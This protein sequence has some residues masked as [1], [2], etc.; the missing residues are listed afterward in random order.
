MVFISV[1]IDCTSRYFQYLHKQYT[2]EYE[3]FTSCV[4]YS[5]LGA[6]TVTISHYLLN[7]E[8]TLSLCCPVINGNKESVQMTGIQTETLASIHFCKTTL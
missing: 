8:V 2:P 5:A 3:D 7:V 6:A 4:L 1:S